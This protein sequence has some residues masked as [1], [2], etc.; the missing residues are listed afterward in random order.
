[1]SKIKDTISAIKSIWSTPKTTSSTY[2]YADIK[3]LQKQLTNLRGT[4]FD[5]AYTNRIRDDWPTTSSIPYTDI[6]QSLPIIIARSR[7]EIDN[8]GIASGIRRTIEN[9]VWGEGPVVQAQVKNKKGDLLKVVNDE[10]EEAWV[11]HSEEMDSSGHSDF[12]EFG[13]EALKTIISSGSVITNRVP[14]IKGQYL[15]LAY[16]ML[17]PDVLD[18]S[19][20]DQ[21]ITQDMN[22]RAK[23][24]L[25]GIGIDENYRP[26]NYH[27]KGIKSPFSAEYMRHFYIRN[28]PNQVIGVPWLHASLPDLFDYRQLK[29]DTLTKS[30]ILACIAL[31]N[32]PDGGLFPGEE[33]KNEDG[34]AEWEPASIIRTKDKPEV[35]QAT[36]DLNTALKPLLNRVLLDACSGIGT[37]YMA[38]S[39]DMDGVNFA[40]S[41]TNLNEDRA[42]YKSIRGWLIRSIAQYFWNNFVYQCV[43]EGKVSISP[44]VFISDPYKYTR[45]SF[46]FPPWDWVDPRADTD[47]VVNLSAAGLSTL[48]EVCSKKGID[49]R[50]HV[51][52]KAEEYLYIKQIAEEK[53]IPIKRLLAVI[54]ENS[55]GRDEEK[56]ENDGK[57]E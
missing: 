3:K 8:N 11:R 7:R 37:S 22:E 51:T 6:K 29:E 27:I 53:D 49:W 13:K 12:N 39:R 2:R 14:P 31:W 4:H 17:E 38:V 42:G 33:M 15:Q 23:Q 57:Q 20:D 5:A 28:R 21:K 19:M 24:V 1:M 32:A 55:G 36:G 41:R 26:V 46:Q 30:R 16:Q 54:E 18:S 44:Q 25:H 34:E 52:Q 56:S 35:I 50:D 48:K 9:N 40:A 43:I 10:L 45:V 47:A